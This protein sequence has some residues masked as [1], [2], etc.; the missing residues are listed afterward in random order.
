MRAD[1]QLGSGESRLYP[2]SIALS[3]PSCYQMNRFLALIPNSASMS[4]PRYSTPATS[5]FSALAP[6]K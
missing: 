6:T 5:D 4:Q 3:Q 2:E 1:V